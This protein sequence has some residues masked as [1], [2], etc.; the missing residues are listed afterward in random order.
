MDA[1]GYMSQIG[2]RKTQTILSRVCV[3]T[4]YALGCETCN[5]DCETYNKH[6]R[7]WLRKPTQAEMDAAGWGGGANND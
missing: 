1:A 4:R 7:V 6:Y 5:K 2:T 3:L